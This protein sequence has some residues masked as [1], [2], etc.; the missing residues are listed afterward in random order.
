MYR[1]IAFLA[2]TFV[3]DDFAAVVVAKKGSR[4][5]VVPVQQVMQQYAWI[6]YA[7]VRWNDTW[8]AKIVAVFE[9]DDATEPNQY[10]GRL[11]VGYAN[12]G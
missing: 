12:S 6:E 1:L 4:V 3:G 7:I 8:I 9:E 10:K 2:T 5:L 11:E